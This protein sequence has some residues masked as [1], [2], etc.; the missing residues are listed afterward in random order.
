MLVACTLVGQPPPRLPHVGVLS[1]GSEV[2]WPY[3]DALRDGLRERGY[4]DGQ[5]VVLDLQAG[6]DTRE[7][8]AAAAAELVRQKPDVIVVGGTVGIEE[9]KA[10]TS[11]I[12]IVMASSGDP[13]GTGLVAS[14]GR[15]GGNVTGLTLI[16]PELGGKRLEILKESIPGLTRVAFLTEPGNPASRPLGEELEVAARVLG[17][18]LRTVVA[19]TAEEI[20]G[21]LAAVHADGAQALVV[22]GGALFINQRARIADLANRYR[23]PAMYQYGEFVDAGGLMAYGM[24]MTD[25]WRR[26]AYYVERILKGGNPAEMPIERPMHFTLMVNLKAAQGLGLTLPRPVLEQASEVITD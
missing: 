5:N 20:D 10:A 11:T 17:L 18:D 2:T 6:A 19:N 12:P 4:V 24:R 3:L 23:L 9:V 26:S 7:Q 1:P 16:S 8:I 14:L 21:A 13:V 15:P 22:F 25:L